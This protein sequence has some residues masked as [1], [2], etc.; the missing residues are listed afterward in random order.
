MTALTGTKQE[1]ALINQKVDAAKELVGQAAVVAYEA[2]KLRDGMKMRMA[3]VNLA[4]RR[5][6][7]AE[8]LLERERLLV[9]TKWMT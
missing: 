4:H 3:D 1:R 7:L 9:V 6:Q 2:S 5:L 8:L